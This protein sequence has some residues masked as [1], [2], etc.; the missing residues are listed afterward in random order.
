MSDWCPFALFALHSRS[1]FLCCC[2]VVPDTQELY[3]LENTHTWIHMLYSSLLRSN[4]PQRNR[5][6]LASL[7][8]WSVD[9]IAVP[10]RRCAFVF[11]RINWNGG[12]RDKWKEHEQYIREQKRAQTQEIA[13]SCLLNGCGANE[14]WRPKISRPTPSA[15]TS[16]SSH[17]SPFSLN[18]FV[19]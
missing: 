18:V 11:D 17:I 2:L 3:W 5:C 6:F 4:A 19:R 10:F 14:I 8:N 15:V 7:I 1:I 16:I 12:K 9:V 13:L